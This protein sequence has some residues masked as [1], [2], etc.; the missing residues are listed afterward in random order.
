MYGYEYVWGC[1]HGY[2]LVKMYV[3]V[4]THV[5]MYARVWT[6]WGCMHGFEC[7]W[8]CIVWLVQVCV[9]VCGGNP[10]KHW[11]PSLS[12]H[13]LFFWGL[14][15]PWTL[16]SHLVFSRLEASKPFCFHSPLAG[17]VQLFWG[18]WEMNSGP[19]SLLLSHLLRLVF[20]LQT[21]VRICP[22]YSVSGLAELDQRTQLVLQRQHPLHGCPLNTHEQE[23]KRPG[24]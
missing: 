22:Q 1:M 11:V 4:W 23:M 8:E 20:C 19:H 17:A 24:L 6:V 9:C 18:C 15:S 7:V 14:A 16:K 13:T 10:G 2:E 5:R 21:S 3:W 12:L